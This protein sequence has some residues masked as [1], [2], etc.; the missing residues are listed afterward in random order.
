MSEENLK[1]ESCQSSM[2][3]DKRGDFVVVH[4]L[5][6]YVSVLEKHAKSLKEKCITMKSMY[7]NC[8]RSS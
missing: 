4:L 1:S 5:L 6:I 8:L 2:E 7:A 3:E